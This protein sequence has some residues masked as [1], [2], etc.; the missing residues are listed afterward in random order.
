M[1]IIIIIKSTWILIIFVFINIMIVGS[2]F[3]TSIYSEVLFPAENT[4]YN[5]KQ[6]CP[7]TRWSFWSESGRPRF[8]ILPCS[9]FS[10][11]CLHKPIVWVFTRFEKYNCLIHRQKGRGLFKVL[12]KARVHQI[13]FACTMCTMEKGFLAKE[14]KTWQ[15]RNSA[16]GTG[17]KR[18]SGLLSIDIERDGPQEML[19]RYLIRSGPLWTTLNFL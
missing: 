15:L 19:N 12:T 11:A 14:D 1:I 2:G 16:T 17:Q 5:L 3:T 6:D 9:S 18:R 7:G 4:D 13:D 10:T 8:R